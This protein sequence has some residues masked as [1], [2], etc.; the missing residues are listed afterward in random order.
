M[1]AVKALACAQNEAVPLVRR[2][3]KQAYNAESVLFWQSEPSKLHRVYRSS[4]RLISTSQLN[5]SPHLHLWPIYH[6]FFMVPYQM[7]EN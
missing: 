7:R 4:P 2:M 3:R 1:L 6:V 5:V